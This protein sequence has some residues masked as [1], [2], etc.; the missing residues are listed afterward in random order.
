MAVPPPML[1]MKWLHFELS[2]VAATFRGPNSAHLTASLHA[3]L[4]SSDAGWRGKGVSASGATRRHAG[5]SSLL[6]HAGARTSAALQPVRMAPRR[7]RGN[8]RG[9]IAH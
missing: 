4:L 8:D 9:H 7:I 5:I 2:R 3:R 1:R 6:R